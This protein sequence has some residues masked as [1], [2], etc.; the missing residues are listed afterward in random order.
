MIWVRHTNSAKVVVGAQ[1][2]LK[3]YIL[4]FDEDNAKLKPTP[5]LW[6]RLEKNKENKTTLNQ[7][8]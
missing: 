2:W 4:K 3:R 7:A 1:V 5:A 8:H 6:M